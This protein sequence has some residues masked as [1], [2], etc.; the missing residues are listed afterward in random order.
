MRTKKQRK[1]ISKKINKKRNI[2]RHFKKR[3]TIKKNKT[4]RN[5]KRQKR[6]SKLQKQSGGYFNDKLHFK[7]FQAPLSID[8]T[9]VNYIFD[10]RPFQLTPDIL[11]YLINN[12]MTLNFIDEKEC[13]GS[14][15]QSWRLGVNNQM[16]ALAFTDFPNLVVTKREKQTAYTSD[17]QTFYYV[18]EIGT[19]TSKID[20]TDYIIENVSCATEPSITSITQDITYFTKLQE[21]LPRYINK[22]YSNL[23]NL[24]YNTFVIRK[25]VGE[26]TIVGYPDP[27]QMN[28]YLEQYTQL[29]E[30]LNL[31]IGVQTDT[32]K[33]HLVGINGQSNGDKISSE[34]I[35]NE[36]DKLINN[37]A[38][39]QHLDYIKQLLPETAIDTVKDKKQAKIR[40]ILN[41]VFALPNRKIH[42]VFHILKQEDGIYKPMILNVRQLTKAHQ[43]VLQE[44]LNII[45]T[46][47][48]TKFGLVP[49]DSFYSYHN[50]GDLF[51]IE[52]EFIH[53]TTKLDTFSHAYQRRI[54]L[55]EL[56]YSCGLPQPFW[57]VVEFEYPIK[58]YRTNMPASTPIQTQRKPIILDMYK[59]IQPLETEKVQNITDFFS[60]P[61]NINVVMC[62]HLPTYEVEVVL[63]KDKTYYFM[64]LKIDLFSYK[65][66]SEQSKIINKITSQTLQP[67]YDCER[68]DYLLS[69]EYSYL[70]TQFDVISNTLN[71][72]KQGWSFPSIK[73]NKI[74]EDDFDK[75]YPKQVYDKLQGATLQ[76]GKDEG[77]ITLIDIEGYLEKKLYITKKDTKYVAW[78]F[79]IPEGQQGKQTIQQPDENR[80]KD[81]YDL[82]D[83]QLLLTIKTKIAAYLKDQSDDDISN[84]K[85]YI[86]RYSSPKHRSLHLQI[87]PKNVFYKS[88][89]YSLD[90]TQNTDTRLISFNNVVNFLKA[91]PDYFKGLKTNL[92]LFTVPLYQFIE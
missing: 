83:P 11:Q 86:N 65:F 41:K 44:L 21:E 51:C 92:A 8:G 14:S 42:Y 55:E 26:Y 73:F 63:E 15:S 68:T 12:K 33:T 19:T 87:L 7:Q 9:N 74:I 61:D 81:L 23:C 60:N 17:N 28:P 48:P 47:I 38:D 22:D 39:I 43:P 10:I 90:I 84:Y 13:K 36:I 31:I 1:R 18:K 56:I 69:H 3:K 89:L 77:P 88:P 25:V 82:T 80:I 75:Y 49:I 78:V 5:S 16:C 29:R 34:N 64:K 76:G 37:N 50:Y 91:Y 67:I 4:K 20:G 46:E 53:P 85:I 40:E 79:N 32:L 27:K 66:D 59:H 72:L 54:T 6:K 70:I 30:D 57:S 24:K 35:D 58:Q 52:T 62:N 2:R 71:P 45:K